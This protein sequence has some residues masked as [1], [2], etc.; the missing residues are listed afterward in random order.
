MQFFN[1]QQVAFNSS[2][3]FPA[4]EFESLNHQAT[5]TVSAEHSASELKFSTS[6]FQPDKV[7][8]FVPNEIIASDQKMQF[9][10]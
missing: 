9:A 6:V 2:E 4:A 1:Q 7:S 10:A 5:K 3:N 8:T